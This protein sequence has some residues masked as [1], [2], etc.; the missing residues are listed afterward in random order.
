MPSVLYIGTLK[1]RQTEV[2][3]STTFTKTGHWSK[4][5]RRMTDRNVPELA[6]L[7][8]ASTD[9]FRRCLRWISLDVVVSWRTSRGYLLVTTILS[10]LV[11]ERY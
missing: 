4:R 2:G 3:P 8:R 11:D 7:C 1:P 6:G 5:V 9:D 10:L